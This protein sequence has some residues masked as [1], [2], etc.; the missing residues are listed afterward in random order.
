MSPR[1][2][3]ITGGAGGLGRALAERR[4]RAGASRPLA[5]GWARRDR[6]VRA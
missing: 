2:V 3:F 1:R 6:E 4:V 5:G